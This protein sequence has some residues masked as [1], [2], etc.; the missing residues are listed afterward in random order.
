M[1]EKP[2]SSG[3]MLTAGARAGMGAL[4]GVAAITAVGALVGSLL[5]PGAIG[6]LTFGYFPNVGA[7]LG[8]WIGGA[9]GL[10][11]GSLAGT[12]GGIAGLLSGAD[13]VERAE[14]AYHAQAHGR[15]QQKV[16]AQAHEVGLMQGMQEGYDHGRQ[17]GFMEG[18]AAVLDRLQQMKMAQ[19]AEEQKPAKKFADNCKRCDTHVTTLEQQRQEAAQRPNERC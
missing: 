8:A 13:K 19:A 6:L 11:Y 15:S 3:A 12:A 2:T 5:L 1:A 16:T 18:Q 10:S 7:T 17:D 4:L 9:V 14:N